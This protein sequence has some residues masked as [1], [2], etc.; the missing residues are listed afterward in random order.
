MDTLRRELLEEAG[1]R[2]VD[3]HLYG[4]MVT[5]NSAPQPYRP[6][7]PHPV[8]HRLIGYGQVVIVGKPGNP[9]DGEKVLRVEV[10]T[11]GQALA[12]FRE[13]GQGW[14]AE[15]YQLAEIISRQS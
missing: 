4:L 9:V 1:A 6:H 2:L 11:L 14:L 13:T 15:L 8:S 7:L 10:V 3:F 12:W 5:H